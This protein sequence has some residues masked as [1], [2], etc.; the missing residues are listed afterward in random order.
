MLRHPHED[1]ATLVG[2]LYDSHGAALYRYAL[3]LLAD[4]AAAEDALQQVFTS[5][6][7]Q[8]GPI[9]NEA[10]YLRRSVRNGIR[11]LLKPPVVPASQEKSQ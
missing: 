8:S 7:R 2:R 11:V 6:L 10:H 4:H 5:V 1:R 3:M 9:D